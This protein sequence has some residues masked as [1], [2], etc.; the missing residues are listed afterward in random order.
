M[1]IANTI[2]HRGF[3]VGTACVLA[4]T[5]IAGAY[6][7][8]HGA[9][10]PA[11]PQPL[12]PAPVPVVVGTATRQDVPVYI[13]G[14]GTVAPFNSVTVRSRVDGELQQVLFSEGQ[15]IR[16]GDVIAVIDPR[17]FEAALE[18]ARARLQQDEAALANAKLIF[19]R[20]ATLGRDSFA[21]QQTVDTDQSSVAQLEAQIA[22]DKAAIETAEI[23]LS[24]TRIVSPLDARAGLRLVDEGN[25][26][27]ATDANGLVVLNQI[28]P[29]AVI[30][31]LPQGDVVT[32]RKALEAGTVT[33][34]AV[35]RDD[36]TVLDT[37]TVEV[38]D[39]Q[40]DA[41]SGTLRVK[42]VFPNA[43]DTLWPG[44][45]VDLRL[46]VATIRAA[47]TVPS[48]A[49]QRG[50]N[51]PFVYTVGT[52]AR[53]AA[54]PVALGQIAGGRAVIASGVDEGRRVVVRGQYRLEPGVAV[55]VSAAPGGE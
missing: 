54:T 39:N 7:F 52:D 10:G 50:P 47:V 13:T 38:V 43:N 2:G 35:S 40:I 31:T 51:G 48:D 3:S 55:A 29:I 27:H 19:A 30:S 12:A 44:L 20:D 28:H 8:Q 37:G 9:P 49:V 22:Q 11:L 46:R 6:A 21:S 26:V 42:S 18:Q 5:L 14:I 33:A 32:V 36:G 45:F 17:A 53:V 24:Y 25:I 23:Q 16:K 1:G 34:Q 41:Q 4:A 15:D